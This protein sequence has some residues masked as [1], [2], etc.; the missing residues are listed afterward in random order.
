MNP[1]EM[2]VTF[3][4]FVLLLPEKLI[5]SNSAVTKHR[6]TLLVANE[7]TSK[8]TMIYQYVNV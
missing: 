4:V 6:T 7:R 3:M 8:L 5:S 1:C 2:P